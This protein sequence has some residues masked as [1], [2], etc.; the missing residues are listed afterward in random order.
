MQQLDL[1]YN[2]LR[3]LPDSFRNLRSLEILHLEGNPLI[4][5]PVCMNELTNL[6]KL[7]LDRTITIPKEIFQL[8]KLEIL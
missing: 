1:S 8:P 5:L 7:Y 2:E 6:C 4:E 3:G